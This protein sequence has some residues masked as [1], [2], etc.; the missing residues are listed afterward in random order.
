LEGRHKSIP[1]GNRHVIDGHAA[2]I[3]HRRRQPQPALA[4]RVGVAVAGKFGV[5]KQQPIAGRAALERLD[6]GRPFGCG[7]EDG[8]HFFVVVHRQ[9]AVTRPRA[10]A[11]PAGEGGGG[12]CCGRQGDHRAGQVS[13]LVGILG[14]RT[15]ADGVGG[16]GVVD[17]GDLCHQDV[18]RVGG[19]ARSGAIGGEGDG[20]GRAD[21]CA[22]RDIHLHRD[23]DRAAGRHGERRRPLERRRPGGLVFADREGHAHVRRVVVGEGVDQVAGRALLDFGERRGDDE[24]RIEGGD[25][26][27]LVGRDR[28]DVAG[29]QAGLPPFQRVAV[30]GIGGG[31]QAIGERTA[32]HVIPHIKI[33]Q[34]I[35]ILRRG[36]TLQ[37]EAGFGAAADVARADGAGGGEPQPRAGVGRRLAVVVSHSQAGVHPVEEA[38]TAERAA[39]GVLDGP[40]V[41]D[42][43]VAIAVAHGLRDARAAGGEH[44]DDGIADFSVT[45]GCGLGIGRV[46]SRAI[47]PAEIVAVAGILQARVLVGILRGACIL[48]I[49]DQRLPLRVCSVVA[50]EADTAFVI[51]LDAQVAIHRV[52]AQRLSGRQD[53]LRR[54]K[55]EHSKYHHKNSDGR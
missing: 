16:E 23:G 39:A 22:C 53:S 24:D 36:D 30:V 48:P 34:T 46:R 17:D 13:G 37:V 38:Q 29:G 32:L 27:A 47:R 20:A 31:V 14:H 35:I 18:P 1:V 9:D 41:A 15:G 4:V 45:D 55:L 11:H 21:G 50:E 2:L 25:A 42:E 49:I 19:D 44:R 6:N 7:G 3:V 40:V 28:P 26:E 43:V 54:G 51:D 10:V 33:G 52:A 12:D 5:V 8:P